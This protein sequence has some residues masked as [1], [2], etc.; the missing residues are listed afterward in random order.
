MTQSTNSHHFPFAGS[1]RVNAPVTCASC[2]CRLQGADNGT[3]RHFNPL[4][5]RDARGCLVACADLA[6]DQDGLARSIVAA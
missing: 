3:W 4:A 6:H 5:G 2:G 1:I